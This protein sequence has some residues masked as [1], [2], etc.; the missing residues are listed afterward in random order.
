MSV[1]L[2]FF[3]FFV[4]LSVSSLSFS[5]VLCS[6]LLSVSLSLFLEWTRKQS[7]QTSESY[8]HHLIFFLESALGADT[9]CQGDLR[10]GLCL[11]KEG[12][13]GSHRGHGCWTSNWRQWQRRHFRDS[14][15][16]STQMSGK[17]DGKFYVSFISV[18]LQQDA[19]KEQ[20]ANVEFWRIVNIK[21]I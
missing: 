12:R 21:N 3:L 13:R 6:T 8:W 2:P 17:N 4:L 5:L 18:F 1:S 14:T 20:N 10:C 16:P 9:D 11:E 19:L 15:S 7:V